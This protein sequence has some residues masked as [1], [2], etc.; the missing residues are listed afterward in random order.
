MKNY[1]QTG[2]IVTVTAPANVAAGD[3]VEVGKLVGVAVADAASGK[4]VNIKTS[5]VF[6]VKKVSAQAWT[7]GA[8]L[9]V[10]DGEAT[11]TASTNTFIGHALEI[12]ANPSATGVVRL[13]V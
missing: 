10:A 13:S 5:G 4:P 7:V 12:A 9:Y 1:I 8:A 3:L 6:T 11:T 2:D